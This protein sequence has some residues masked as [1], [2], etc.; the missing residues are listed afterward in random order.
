MTRRAT[1]RGCSSRANITSNLTASEAYLPDFAVSL[2]D[3]PVLD[4]HAVA[5]DGAATVLV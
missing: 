1:A 2:A 5:I 3:E 4:L